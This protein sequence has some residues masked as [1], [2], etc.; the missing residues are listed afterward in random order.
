MKKFVFTTML[1][2]AAISFGQEHSI[3]IVTEEIPNRLEF[4]A[5]NENETDLDV[6]FELT[7]TNFRQS[8]AKPRFIRVPARSRVHLKT[9]VLMRGKKPSYTFR[10]DVND[11][12]SSRSLV[13]ESEPIKIAPRK[14]ITI[15]IP[16][17]CSSCDSLIGSLTQGPY[18]FT[19]HLL[20]ERQEIRDQL[21][22]S[23]GNR[24]DLDTLQTPVIN[25]GG[26]LYTRVEDYN[27]LLELLQLD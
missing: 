11:S 3:K 24:I 13:R 5:L 9:V 22:R 6:L 23:F 18:N 27:Q 2:I 14:S 16:E 4:Y 15:Y 25:L 1:A 7:G 19:S 26:K 8:A 17:K 12:L 20:G 21:D 10:L